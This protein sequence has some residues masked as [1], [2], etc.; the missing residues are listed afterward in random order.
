MLAIAG[1]KGGCGKTTTALG[2]AEAF[3]RS[4]DASLV[5]DADRQLPNLHVI[6]D[7]DR[8]PTV[9]AAEGPEDVTR[10]AQQVPGE[11]GVG[12][13]PAPLEDESV[14]FEAALGRLHS[15]STRTVVDCPSGAGPDVMEPLMASDRVLVVTTPSDRSVSA[16]ETTIDIARR[17]GVPVAGLVVARAPTVP[18]ELATRI[19]VPV[20]GAVPEADAPL[21]DE[22]ARSTYDEVARKLASSEAGEDVPV[23][24]AAG[25]LA[26]GVDA[27]DAAL[28]G[29]IP[30]GSV[31]VV[32]ADPASQSELL[33]YSATAT[34]GTLYLSTERSD[35]SVRQA[36]ADS[37]VEVGSP[38]V[39][40]VT[41]PERL[42]EA[43]DLIGE[44]PEGA[45]LIVDPMDGLER[46]EWSEYVAFLN[47][48]KRHVVRTESVAFLHCLR[49]PSVPDTRAT[50]K[51][52]ADAVFQV[53]GDGAGADGTRLSIPKLRG[54]G[55]PMAPVELDLV[56]PVAPSV[57]GEAD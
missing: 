16:A 27:V 40:Q 17:A 7:V 26:T 18:E 30:T 3:A 1:A 52:V 10:V 4:G 32:E 29:G 38:T 47:D 33:L 22:S 46:L 9:A 6:A 8:T 36:I 14:D 34:R 51:H 45:T 37:V 39:R 28:G 23:E 35:E 53:E 49:R 11:P 21:T 55:R 24:P 20:L 57:S 19:D 2:V 50:T 42:E 31:V 15:D 44:L 13:L 41:G 48:L 43:G 5:V 54:A 25:Q 12:I 56:Q